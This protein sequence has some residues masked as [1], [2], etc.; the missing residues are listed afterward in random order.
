M[1]TFVQWK[2]YVGPHFLHFDWA[3]LGY[4]FGTNLDYSTTLSGTLSAGATTASTANG[5]SFYT[6]GGLW[7]G[8]GT[9]QSWEYCRYTGKSGN[10]FTGLTR[11]TIN[12]ENSGIHA[13][14]AKVYAFFPL[15]NCDDGELHITEEMDDKYGAV[16]WSA[17]ISGVN[18]PQTCIRNNHIIVIQARL[19]SAGGFTNLLVG[20]I[21][22]PTVKDDYQRQRAWSLR[23]VDASFLMAAQRV[24]GIKA[25]DLDIAKDG[26]A[27]GSAALVLPSEERASGDFV[28][29]AP[30]LDAGQTIDKGNDTLWL[31][32]RYLGTPMSFTYPNNDPKN[33]GLLKF[34]EIY[35]NP[36]T[37]APAGCRYI[38]L[39]L[40]DGSFKGYALYCANGGSGSVEWLLNGTGSVGQGQVAILCEDAEVFRKLNP[41]SDA[42]SVIQN[43]AWFQN[44][45]V[46]GQH[47]R[48]RRGALGLWEG[49]V[50]WGDGYGYINHPD[51]NS[52]APYGTPIAAPTPG[53]TLRYIHSRT[54]GSG[55]AAWWDVG[56]VRTG[57]YDITNGTIDDTVRQWVKIDL[58][59]M[60]LKLDGD[61][62]AT[63]PTTGGLLAIKD[64]S[65][66]CTS[67]L[68]ASGTIQIADEQITYSSKTDAG[69]IVAARHANGTTAASHT[70]EDA[71][72]I[73]DA[74][75]N[76]IAT[77]AHLVKSVGWRRFNGTIYPKDFIVQRSAQPGDVRSPGDSGY[78]SDYTNIQTVNGNVA[79][80]WSATFSPSMRIKH[81]LIEIKTMTT[82]PARAR[83]NDIFAMLDPALYTNATWLADGTTAGAIIQNILLNAGLQA[84]AITVNAG[85]PALTNITTAD[86][87]AWT[88]ATDMAE[89]AGCRIVVDRA[90]EVIISPDTSWT[91]TPSATHI[92]DEQTAESVDISYRNGI[93]VSQYK[94]KWRSP[95]DGDRGEEV[96]PATAGTVGSVMESEELVF[97]NAAAAQ[98][99]ARKYYLLNKYPYTL[100][101]S[102]AEAWPEFRPGAIHNVKWT[103]HN[104]MKQID[105]LY[106]VVGCD[107][108]IS[109]MDWQSSFN[110]VQLERE[111]G[112]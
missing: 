7:I 21:D 61:I 78:G 60:G 87:N 83:L 15:E 75:N 42:A 93:S 49:Q 20:F 36:P 111:A 85:T 14:G 16:T 102:S 88:V 107:H 30:N 11:E 13:S 2:A 51:L 70:D 112:W 73:I 12:V 6:Q 100:V 64:D 79:S 52:P 9:S 32:E 110:L 82:D 65:G 86:D 101:V 39:R 90:S 77:D 76:N 1:S 46:A 54:S 3:Q 43:R 81:L 34:D 59:G 96:Y 56:M 18:F 99:A 80:S 84:T 68:P 29:A 105:R 28:A 71:I 53:Q 25:G 24:K 26:T 95:D 8:P 19:G 27:N 31:S 108:V 38:R 10:S 41:L 55:A 22:S 40:M 44:M 35:I 48:L 72:Y 5:A 50:A 63:V 62:T 4:G 23:I 69:V 45:R 89:F 97:A 66:P 74:A 57:G 91:T 109:N 92:W 37:G 104:E 33:N 58:P 94:V 106:L 17:T 67:G 98:A 47:L 103:L